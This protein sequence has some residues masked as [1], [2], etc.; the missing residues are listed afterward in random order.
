MTT[1]LFVTVDVFQNVIGTWTPANASAELAATTFVPVA[2]PGADK[3]HEHAETHLPGVI[4][5]DVTFGAAVSFGEGG[6]A[7]LQFRITGD[8]RYGVSVR[9]TGF[10]IYRQLHKSSWIW[11]PILP[12][13]D[14]PMQ[15]ATN[16]PH[17]VSVT[18]NGAVF[19]V[20]VDGV[21]RRVYDDFIPVGALDGMHFGRW[22]R[23]APS[24]LP[25][26]KPPQTP[27]SSA[28]S[29]CYTAL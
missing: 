20:T 22:V 12:D 25:R 27:P 13:G 2:D 1:A 24:N 28:T 5:A 29:R 7:H 21:S 8:G 3:D 6:D 10:R 23:G 15:L 16:K 14:V 11:E 19:D 9:Q 4:S 18:C 26:C 17:V